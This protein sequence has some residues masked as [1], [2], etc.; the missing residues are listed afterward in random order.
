[1]MKAPLSLR[2]VRLPAIAAWVALSLGQAVSAMA[3]TQAPES[4][5][6]AAIISNMLLFVEWP[7]GASANAAPS[8]QLVICYQEPSPVANALLRLDGKT[9]KGKSLKV[10]QIGAGSA[11]GC[12]ALY[13]SPGNA[14][15]MSKLLP[16]LVSS[17]VLLAGDSPEY[18][19]NGVMLNLDL[20]AGRVVFDID[21]PSAQK[22]GL[23]ISSKA[24]RLA[25]QVFE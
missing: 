19:R 22:A 11:A 4:D 12:H 21:L 24:L 25:R 15:A 2:F 23:Q 17:P 1:M 5:L 20:A 10:I 18:T 16:V 9:L 3:Q 14:A 13:L 8:D 6:K 7:A